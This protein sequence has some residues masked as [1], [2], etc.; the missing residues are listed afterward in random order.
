[1]VA[2]VLVRV[3]GA[4]AVVVAA[5]L[6]PRRLLLQLQLQ[7]LLQRL[8]PFRQLQRVRFSRIGCSILKPMPRIV[9]VRL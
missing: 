3:A 9:G 8:L 2:A 6:K 1:V 4:E 5:V 7:R